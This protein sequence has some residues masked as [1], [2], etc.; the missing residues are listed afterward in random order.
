M[1]SLQRVQAVLNNQLPDRVPVCLHNVYSAIHEAGVSI[2]DYRT[3]PEV[4]ARVYIQAVEKYSYDCV[5]VDPD[6]TM[7]AEALGAKSDCT[8]G[9]PAH[10]YAPALDRLEDVDKLKVVD[11]E[12][13]GRIPVL[14]EAIRILSKTFGH[15][16]SI[17]GNCDQAA[18]SLAC[19]V[20]GNENF[21]MDM[22]DDPENPALTQLLEICHQSHLRVHLAA[23]KAGAHFTSLGDSFSGP[24]VVSPT[25]FKKFARPYHERL[26]RELQKENIF[27]LIHICG[28]TTLIVDDM[29]Q[30]DF[31]AFELD[32]KTDAVKAKATAGKHHVLF[33]NIDPANIIGRGTVAQIRQATSQL[34]ATWKPGGLFIL[35]AGCALSATTPSENIRAFLE[36]AHE[37]G[38]Y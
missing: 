20:R 28:N 5:L 2:Q 23:K 35:N 29:A 26:I 31:C 13:D 11:P 33:G 9:E 6:T 37:F 27:T 24:D 1:N 3:D 38:Q 36:T 14:L 16:V 21:L 7:L 4:M 25:L 10:I 30:Y 34:I 8:P 17:R 32:Y 18:F 19:L 22:M 15:D 12:R